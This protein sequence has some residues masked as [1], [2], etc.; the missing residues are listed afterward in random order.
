M[1]GEMNEKLDKKV[2]TRLKAKLS[3]S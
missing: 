2:G 3:V 1:V